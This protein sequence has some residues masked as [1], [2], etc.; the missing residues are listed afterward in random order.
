MVIGAEADGELDGD[1]R[2][3]KLS[4]GHLSGEEEVFDQKS[5]NIPV[6]RLSL[7]ISRNKIPLLVQLFIVLACGVLLGDVPIWIKWSY[8]TF[9]YPNVFASDLHHMR[10]TILLS[11]LDAEF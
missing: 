7:R 10:G 3:V 1:I 8:S 5:P 4:S 11:P 9:T 2:T 6:R